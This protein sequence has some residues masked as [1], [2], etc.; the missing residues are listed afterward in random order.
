MLC[1]DGDHYIWQPQLAVGPVT[2][3]MRTKVFKR[4]SLG[5]LWF[6]KFGAGGMHVKPGRPYGVSFSKTETVKSIEGVSVCQ[7]FHVAPKITGY[8]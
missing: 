2:S 6:Q 3:E 8:F 1:G 4:P 5:W 7:L